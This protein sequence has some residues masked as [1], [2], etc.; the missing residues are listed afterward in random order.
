MR[1]QRRL[2]VWADAGI[3]GGLCLRVTLYWLACLAA[4]ALMLAC[5]MAI[6]LPAYSSKQGLW[7]VVTQYGP[8][9]TA[10]LLVLPLALLDGLVFSNR[11]AG[12][13]RQLLSAMKRAAAGETVQPVRLRPKDFGTCQELASEFNRMLARLQ[14]LEADQ[15][16]KQS[17]SRSNG[18]SNTLFETEPQPAA[19]A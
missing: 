1:R 12:P 14:A 4:V 15:D 13:M 9:L 8:P 19:L 16:T 5:R 7:L 10:S 2:R 18:C 3:Q 17:A 6:E 11:F